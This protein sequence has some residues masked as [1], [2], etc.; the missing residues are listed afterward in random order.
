[1]DACHRFWT[2]QS[3]PVS[4]LM[5]DGVMS[6]LL[7]TLESSAEPGPAICLLR[8]NSRN[9]LSSYCV[10]YTSVRCSALVYRTVRMCCYCVC[11][12]VRVYTVHPHSTVYEY[13]GRE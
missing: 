1:M 5:R 4:T 11:V 12:C 9:V 2:N 10:L 13:S 3:M 6:G 8:G 7:E